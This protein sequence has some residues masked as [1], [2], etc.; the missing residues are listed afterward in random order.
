MA[1]NADSKHP[2]EAIKFLNL[3]NTD[4]EVRNLFNFGIEGVHYTLDDNGQVVPI[5]PTDGS[6]N[7][8]PDAQP[9]YVAVQYTQGNW[10]ILKT[11]GGQFPDPLDKWDQFRASNKEAVYSGT[12][13]FTPDLTA[14]PLQL[15]NIQMVWEKYFSGL[16]T[17]SV[18]VDSVLP[19]FISE[20]RQAGID[21]VRDEV[22]RQLDAWRAVRGGAS[23][24]RPAN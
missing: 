7:P 14:M 10:F 8:I 17:G 23:A 19:K 1:V 2:V 20:L 21:E 16:M 11:M 3:L 22:Q 5:P 24:I 4:P 9:G 12:L 13:G 15:K 6:G 18:D